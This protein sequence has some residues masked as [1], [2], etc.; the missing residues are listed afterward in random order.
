[1]CL[2]NTNGPDNDQDRKYKYSDM[3]TRNDIVKYVNSNILFFRSYDQFQFY[4]MVRLQGQKVK[5]VGTYGK[6]LSL[7]ILMWNIKASKL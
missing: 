5:I 7:R 4:N 2:W 6:F 1:M 3:V